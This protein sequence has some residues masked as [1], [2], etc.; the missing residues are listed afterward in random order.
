M[1][2]VFPNH[3]MRFDLESGGFRLPHPTGSSLIVEGAGMESIWTIRA[4][5][6]IG[7]RVEARDSGGHKPRIEVGSGPDR[8]WMIHDPSGTHSFDSIAGLVEHLRKTS[9]FAAG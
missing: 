5:E 1:D 2:T 8:K 6:R 9:A 4:L 3:V 7:M